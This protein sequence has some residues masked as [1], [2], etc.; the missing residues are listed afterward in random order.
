VDYASLAAFRA[1]AH[2]TTSLSMYTDGTDGHEANG[3]QVDPGF[4]NLAALDY[5]PTHASV[6]TGAK[7]VT[8]LIGGS[9]ENWKGALDPAGD[10]SEV[11]PRP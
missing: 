4:V 5:R 2:K 11:G 7:N 3:V 10:G 9:F 1:S 6:I 8:A